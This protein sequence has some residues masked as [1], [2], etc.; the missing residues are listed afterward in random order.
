MAK[1]LFCSIDSPERKA[2]IEQLKSEFPD[3]S[4]TRFIPAINIVSE[5][6]P[7]FG[8]LRMP[9]IEAMR[10]YFKNNTNQNSIQLEQS[11]IQRAEVP[12]DQSVLDEVTARVFKSTQQR[13]DRVMLISKLFSLATDQL[14][15]DSGLPIRTE[16]ERKDFIIGHISDI[17]DVVKAEFDT[18]GV[19]DEYQKQEFEKINT[20]WQELLSEVANVLYYTEGVALSFFDR[21]AREIQTNDGD[22]TGRQIEARDDDEDSSYVIKDNWMIK[23]RELDLRDTLSQKVRRI[24]H[25]I[26]RVNKNGEVEVDDLGFA[27][28]LDA[29]YAHLKLLSEISK[30]NNSSEFDEAIERMISTNPWVKAVKQQLDENEQLKAAFYHDLRKEFVP[31]WVQVD[32]M[33]KQVN[34]EPTVLYYIR[35]W[36][37]NQ[38]QGNILDK[39]SIYT[40]THSFDKEAANRGL[41]KIDELRRRFH[42]GEPEEVLPESLTE[43]RNLLNAVG[44]D[45]SEG[46]IQDALSK[47][48]KNIDTVFGDLTT[49][50]R[51]VSKG[52]SDSVILTE[53]YKAAYTQIAEL[54]DDIPQGVTIASFRE[55]NKSYQSF[56]NPSYLGR[57]L[58]GIKGKNALQYLQQ[59]F[60]RYQQF[61]KNGEYRLDILRK[62]A[63]AGKYR[64]LLERKVVL[65]KDKKEFDDWTEE[66]YLQVMLNEFFSSPKSMTGEVSAYYYLPLLADAPSAEFIRFI[67]YTDTTEKKEDGTYRT[68]EECIIPKLVDIVKQELDRIDMCYERESKIQSGEV[69]EIASLDKTG[70]KFLFFPDLNNI[71]AENGNSFRAEYKRLQAISQFEADEYAERVIG[72]LMEEKVAEFIANT[73]NYVLTLP[74]NAGDRERALKNFYYN[75]ALAYAELVQLTTTDL[76][77]YK[78]LT[79]FQKRYKEVYAM[80]QRLYT[81]T[82]HGK[83]FQNVLT[84]KDINIT[85]L[86]YD[87]VSQALDVAVK[88]KRI[89][90]IDKDYILSQY[91]F[92]AGDKLKTGLNVADAQAY[93][94]LESY[95]SLMDMSGNWTDEMEEAYQRIID[96]SAKW[97]R[98]D[99]DTL[100]QSIKPFT[101]T[102]IDQDSHTSH[103]RIKIPIQHKTAEYLLLALYQKMA[104]NVYQSDTLRALADFMDGNNSAHQKIDLVIFESGVKTGNQGAI[105]IPVNG[106]FDEVKSAL[107]TAC[108]NGTFNPEIVKTISMEDYGFQVQNPEHLMDHI[109]IIGAQ[110]RR[111]IDSDLPEGSIFKLDGKD[112]TKQELHDLYQEILTENILDSFERVNKKFSTIEDIEKTLQDEM[113][114][115]S[116]YSE[117]ERKACTLV[118]RNGRKVFQIPL[119]DPI[120]Y[121]RIQQ[122]LNSTIKKEV[123]KQSIR[124]G[125][126]AQVSSMGLTKELQVRFHDADGN[127][128]FT[129]EEFNGQLKKGDIKSNDY[130]RLKE[131]QKKYKSFKE[132]EA[133][134]KSTGQAYWEVYLPAWAKK[135][136]PVVETED[137]NFDITKIPDELREC[138]GLRIPTEAKY[139]MQPIFIKG[140]LPQANG[141]AIMMP[142]DIVKTTGSDFDFDKVYVY[143]KEFFIDKGYRQLYDQL[144]ATV[145]ASWENRESEN[146]LLTAI[147]GDE[148]AEDI[149][150]AP[151]GYKAWLQYMQENE[152]E[153]LEAWAK[154][155]SRIKA[156][157]Y[158]YN[159]SAQE[160][161]RDAR[162]NAII[163]IATAVLTNPSV[164]EQTFKPGGFDEAKR[165][166]R[167]INVLSVASFNDI[168]EATGETKIK[169]ALHKLLSFKEEQLDSL[170]EKVAPQRDALSPETQIYFHSQNSNGGKMIGVYAV[171]NAAHA[172]GEWVETYIKS[173]LT[174]FG[175][176][177][178]KLDAMTMDNGKLISDTLAQFLAAS[179]DNVKDPVLTALNQNL[180]T[181]DLTVFLARLGLPIEQ[182][183]LLMCCPSYGAG[184]FVDENI[185]EE[186]VAWAIAAAKKD[187]LTTAQHQMYMGAIET[188]DNTTLQKLEGLSAL[189]REERTTL[190]SIMKGVDQIVAQSKLYA[191]TLTGITQ[192]GRGESLAS[193]AGPTLA[194][195]IVRYIRLEDQVNQQANPEKLVTTN[196]LDLDF[197]MDENYDKDTMRQEAK[198]SGVPFLQVATKCGVVGTRY[199]LE[200]FFPQTKQRI[201]DL[202]LNK[203]TGLRGYINTDKMSNDSFA[204]LVNEFF[205]DL[206]SYVLTSTD[207]F[208]GTTI[209]DKQATYRDLLNNFPDEFS[210]IK[211]KYPELSNNSLIRKLA[212]VNQH[213]IK[214][215]VF[216]D[217]ANLS[218]RQKQVIAQDWT[219]LLVSDNP[220]IKQFAV[221]LFRYG[222]LSGLTFTGPQ[223][224]IQLAPNTI[225][226]AIKDYIDGLDTLMYYNGLSLEP[227]I[228]QFIRNRFTQRG[229]VRAVAA[230]TPEE[231][232]RVSIPSDQSIL[233]KD[234]V[235]EDGNKKEYYRRLKFISVVEPIDDKGNGIVKY[236]RFSQLDIAHKKAIYEPTTPLGIRGS[237]RE[238]YYG[239]SSPQTVVGELARYKNE[240]KDSS[241]LDS[242]EQE[243]MNDLTRDEIDYS[244]ES[245]TTVIE[246]IIR[247]PETGEEIC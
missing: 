227:F 145:K 9:T 87:N 198:K 130:R 47:S 216:Q 22:E 213:G 51:G 160:N 82:K 67:R 214:K 4:E 121:S 58:N 163:D 115:N 223:S 165:V 237:F 234:T 151:K 164:T 36:T 195:N 25:T 106:S 77:Y 224:Y 208:G 34:A 21:S 79:D 175:K 80:T 201:L 66:D 239:A 241:Y 243:Y 78:N 103:G 2:L 162:N 42:N 218:K 169:D 57:M 211:S 153:N 159:K 137:G 148:F 89:S 194:D 41:E 188:G 93:R 63:S 124:R 26:E 158:N 85:S 180:T 102:Q 96:P 91:K 226:R 64:D 209:E 101:F 176:T 126:C 7:E 200:K 61:F 122:L 43:I 205:L 119:Y 181:G 72:D 69:Q 123:T 11:Y 132:Y 99:F 197:I 70:K 191:E 170:L 113:A 55:V 233:R 31:Y 146:T 29:D 244:N 143:L 125:T 183:A 16:K 8:L 172:T 68:M 141:S 168:K 150:N 12:I 174:I 142:A 56:S 38:E 60:G 1:R 83:P 40:T 173:P 166:A 179:V 156:V 152:K 90:S 136:F 107:E 221:D 52:L 219:A 120:Q 131:I 117:E 111:L 116:R 217:S 157:K 74:K 190:D 73:E 187:N 204:K 39:D 242:L 84:L 27:R 86:I 184:K 81:G 88:E 23:A 228:E 62:L 155:N 45:F 24:L 53:E 240:R 100:W 35:E 76:A 75:N 20:C 207:T 210:T 133:N 138:I 186:K 229:F 206:Y 238:Y 48:N 109:E 15:E 6:N 18:E 112:Y 135:F 144:P 32:N 5:S 104:Q 37:Y 182:I 10:E 203:E 149:E 167:L 215:V 114:G 128:I 171:G 245:Q 154:E 178:Q 33:T 196:L 230:V 110:F 54:F 46:T 140:F 59:E 127:L 192:T 161:S 44:I 193:A 212:S 185:T 139:S 28:Y 236:Y 13:E 94:S 71:K 225:K 232:D 17:L 97:D 65:H 222:Q 247:D 246:D 30:I 3:I 92:V 108:V 49:I 202:L 118:E 235:Y 199:L 95:R 220:E 177:Y 189:S 134:T 50:L 105:Q 147:F 19:E 129:E 98:A 231:G 14:I